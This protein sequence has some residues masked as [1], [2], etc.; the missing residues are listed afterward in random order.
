MPRSINDFKATFTKD[1]ARPS[2]FDVNIPIPLTLIP[3]VKSARNLVYRCENAQLP[4]RTFATAEQKIGS[5]PVEKYPYLTTFNDIDLT[6]IVDDDMQQRIFFDAWLNF[7][8]PQ[9][10]YNFRYKGD[11]STVITINQYDVQNKLTYSINLYD[12]YPV[13]MN[14]MDL[15]WSSDGTH[16][17]VVTFAYTYWKN[18]SLQSLGMELLDAGLGNIFGG[19]LEGSAAGAIATGINSIPNNISG[20]VTTKDTDAV[21]QPGEISGGEGE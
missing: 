7:I 15:D 21:Y 17:L 10:N 18:N 19:L 4:G 9:Y 6:F 8:N 1:L 2:R 5:N 3:Y 11:Y 12:A 14:Q 16:K 13:S 20:G